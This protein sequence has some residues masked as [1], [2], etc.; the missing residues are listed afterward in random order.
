VKETILVADSKKLSAIAVAEIL[1]L[2]SNGIYTII[3]TKNK[4]K[5]VSCKHLKIIESELSSSSFF[6]VHKSHV[7]NLREIGVYEK[8]KGGNLVMSDG[9]IVPVSKRKK[10]EFLSRFKGE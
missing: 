3:H 6:R 9:S 10:S 5:F 2:E 7:V 4:S 1:R 8:G